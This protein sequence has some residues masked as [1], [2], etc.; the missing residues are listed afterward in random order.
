MNKFLSRKF[1][2]A[3]L[4]I[5]LNMQ[6]FGAVTAFP[7]GVSS[8]GVPVLPS[9]NGFFT[10]GSVYFVGSTVVGANDTNACTSTTLP[11]ATI[12]GA[13]NKATANQGDVIYVMPG[14][15]ETLT[16]A[17]DIDIDVAGLSIIGVGR[18]T[19]RPTLTFTTA[20]TADID[21]DA[22]NI[23]FENFLLVCGVD[24]LAG[25][26]DINASDVTLRNIET[27]DT[28]SVQTI[29]WILADSNADRLTVEGSTSLQE[30]AGATAWLQT[31]SIQNLVVRFNNIV[32]DYS[33]G[34]IYNTP[35]GLKDALIE[36]NNMDNFNAVDQNIALVATADGTVRYNTFRIATDTVGDFVAT[37]DMQLFENYGVNADAETG[38]LEGTASGI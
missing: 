22:A 35:Q 3:C 1:L 6:V 13:I 26:L 34:N 15:A 32:G 18:G 30:S 5:L 9:T 37:A 28:S 24:S 17:A 21:F 31:D 20:T 14:H 2:A 27:R 16:A 36:Y 11:C 33:S 4:S 25:P 12:D 8:Y 7:N 38:S 19:N 29:A 23:L 10:T